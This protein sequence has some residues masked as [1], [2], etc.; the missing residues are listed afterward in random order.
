MSKDAIRLGKMSKKQ[1]D[2]MEKEIMLNQ[3]QNWTV[4]NSWLSINS[5]PWTNLN[6]PVQNGETYIKENILCIADT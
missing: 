2:N 5:D 3:N 1:K 4:E 6:N